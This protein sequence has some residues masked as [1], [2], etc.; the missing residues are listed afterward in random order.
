MNKSRTK[1]L[2]V[3]HVMLMIYSF[4]GVCSKLASG[5]KMLSPKFCLYYA[6]IIG[7]LGGYA[8]GWQKI[9]KVLPLSTAFSNKAVTLI[10]ALI[11]GILFF[12]EKITIGKVIGVVMVI[13]GVVLFSTADSKGD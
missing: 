6:C 8:I 1:A 11:W 2:I 13:C 4:S 3:L 9:I 12:G 10:W 7:L 5:E